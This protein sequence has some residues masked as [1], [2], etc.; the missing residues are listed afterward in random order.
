[1]YY[2]NSLPYT[3]L[4]ITSPYGNREIDIP[5]ATTWHAGVDLGTDRLKP[6]TV[7]N[8]GPVVSVMQGTVLESK[9]NSARGWLV[10]V[11]HGTK[12]GKNIR[13]LYQHLMEQ[14]AKVGTKVSA[15]KVIGTMGNT[16]VG[17]QLHLHFELRENDKP[18]DPTWHLMNIKKIVEDEEDMM[19]VY[20]TVSEL[21]GDWK[22]AVEWAIKV[23]IIAG[24]GKTL[25]L[26][27]SEVKSL[28]F[29]Y[30]DHKRNNTL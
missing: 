7:K 21:K 3:P 20:E 27:E 16:G 19:K 12:D 6:H 8:G 15:G 4:R 11:Y 30:R 14:G 10:V 1:M 13:T 17:A 9:W 29:M 26:R 22:I 23:G 18:V 28:V 24:N 25:G 2:F 5:G